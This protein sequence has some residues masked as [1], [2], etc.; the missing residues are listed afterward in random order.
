MTT[1]TTCSAS[2][3]ALHEA[4]VANAGGEC[5]SAAVGDTN[6]MLIPGATMSMIEQ[7][8]LPKD[9]SYKTCSADANNYARSEAIAAIYGKRLDV[10]L[11]DSN[12]TRAVI[13]GT[14][15]KP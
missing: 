14:A 8:I 5:N 4:C 6:R 11:R 12:P 2:L 9:G 1:R 10:A 3:G 15:T 7:N 13:R